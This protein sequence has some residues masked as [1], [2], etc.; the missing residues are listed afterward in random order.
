MTDEIRVDLRRLKDRHG[1]NVR[2]VGL[3]GSYTRSERP[4]DVD[5]VVEAPSRSKEAVQSFFREK[6]RAFPLQ[7]MDYGGYNNRS[8]ESDE[9][10]Y[11][12]LVLSSDDEI[13]TFHAK[14]QSGVTYV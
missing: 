4:S 9:F 3:F 5:V 13:A 11:H 2:R 8:A 1:L 7:R 6:G 12:V 14:N 10:G